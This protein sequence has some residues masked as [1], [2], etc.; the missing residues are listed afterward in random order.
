MTSFTPF[1]AMIGGT[2]IGIAAVMMMGLNG[3][4]MGMSGMSAG[5]LNKPSADTP[6]RISFFLGTI[7]A[8]VLAQIFVP[9][10]AWVHVSSDVPLLVMAGFLVGLGTRM[11][12]GCTSGHGVCG[13]ASLSIRSMIAVPIFMISAMATVF[14][15]RHILGIGI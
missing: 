10:L 1:L 3:R 5:L 8:V 4:I 14:F 6:W 7:L 12:G 9:G 15:V 2:M 11:G 13:I